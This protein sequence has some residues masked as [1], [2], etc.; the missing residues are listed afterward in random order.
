MGVASA[1]GR[2]RELLLTVA[3]ATAAALRRCFLLVQ[4]CS[5][6][7][8]PQQVTLHTCCTRHGE[9]VCMVVG[10]MFGFGA[11][12]SA[13]SAVGLSENWVWAA[14][15][16]AASTTTM[17]KLCCNHFLYLLTLLACTDTKRETGG[18]PLP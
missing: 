6:L 13:C 3:R 14:R 7:M 8:M 10:N 4:C 17:L 11:V 9:M 2:N 12:A 1:P 16:P 18:R 15:Q 5:K